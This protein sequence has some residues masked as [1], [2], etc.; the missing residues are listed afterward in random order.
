MQSFDI[1]Q[2]FVDYYHKR[3]YQ[4]LPGGSLLDP[5][6]PMT[7]VGSAGLS[8]IETA[9]ERG[10]DRTGE[11]YVL[12]QTCFRHFDLEKVGRSPVHLSLFD[13]GGAFSFGQLNKEATLR[14]IWDFLISELGLPGQWIW[15]TYFAGG[16]L[17]RHYLEADG[18]T[19]QAWH[20][21][22]LSS[23]HLVGLGIQGSFWKQGGGLSGQD[24]FR[25][26]GPTTELF[27]DRGP[28]WGCGPECR[29]GCRCG[30]FIEIANVLF[31][32]SQ[33]DQLSGSLNP[34]ITPFAETVIGAERVAMCRFGKSSVFDLE[35]LASLIEFV[36]SRGQ[37]T[38]P[39]GDIRSEQV[40]ADHIRA[41]LFLAADGAP[42]PGKGGQARIM[43]M[44]IR[45]LLT[46]KKVLG[47]TEASF[48]ANLIDI[49]LELYQ[50]Q[51]PN[52]KGGRGRQLS[53][54]AMESERFEQTLAAGYRQLDRVTQKRETAAIS[55]QQALDLV[56]GHGLPLPL[57]ELTLDQRGIEFDHRE[58]WEAHSRWRDALTGPE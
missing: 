38:D 51:H 42:P 21:I 31:I 40:I 18:E 49:T 32:H 5:S 54:F 17:D 26:C 34:L 52:L 48:V 1:G 45:G 11:R 22:G 39:S 55:G 14:R 41:L 2:H 44:L 20:D 53:Y 33:I 25:K 16:E 6:V 24:R 4:V 37:G 10:E 23:S 30:R 9:V 58:Y 7:F 27:F 28:E 8:Q 36:R 15:A 12:L 43:R 35:P 19:L 50:A 29:P 57:L 46:H 56:K 13:M 47:I 3:G